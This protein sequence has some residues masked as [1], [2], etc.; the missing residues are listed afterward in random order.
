MCYCFLNACCIIK[1]Y[2]MCLGIILVWSWAW[3]GYIEVQLMS[4]CSW[5]SSKSCIDYTI[6]KKR[7]IKCTLMYQIFATYSRGHLSKGTLGHILWFCPKIVP[8][9]Q[10]IFTW[11][12]FIN[13]RLNQILLAVWLF[14][15]FTLPHTVQQSFMLGMFVAKRIILKEWKAT[16]A[17]WLSRWVTEVVSEILEKLRSNTH[18]FKI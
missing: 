11:Y 14:C 17:P 2:Q 18:G 3:R 10:S 16:N 12:S 4:G 15:F 6:P 5:F 9:W 13:N 7:L 1:P 8:F